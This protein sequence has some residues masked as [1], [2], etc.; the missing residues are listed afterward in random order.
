MVLEDLKPRDIMTPGAFRNAVAA[1]LAVSGSINC[2]KHLQ[3]TAIESRRR[4]RR[5]PLFNELGRRGARVARRAAERADTIEAFEAAGGARALLKQLEPLLDASALTVTGRTVAEN[6]A[7]VAVANPEVIRPIEPAVLRQGADRHPARIA[8]ARKRDRQARR[9]RPR[10]QGAS[11]RAPR[12]STT[13]A[14]T[15]C[16]RSPTAT[17]KRGHV[18]VVRGMGPKGGPGMAGP[19]SSVV[20]ALDSAGLQSDVAFVTDGQ[21]SGLCNKGLTVAEVSPES[22]VGGP[23]SLVEN[24]DRVIEST[25]I[26]ASLEIDVPEPRS[27]PRAACA[28]ANRCC[29]NRAATRQS[30]SAPCSRCPPAPCWSNRDGNDREESMSEM[31]SSP[32]APYAAGRRRDIKTIN[33]DICVLG[34]GISGVAAALE[35]AK[36]G[37]KVVIVDG[38]PAI[39]GQAIGSI[40]GTIIGLYTHGPE[41][42]QITHGIADDLIKDLTA[43][44]SFS[45]CIIRRSYFQY[46][47]VRLGRWMERKIEAAGVHAVVG[48]TLTAVKFKNRRVEHLDFVTRFGPLRV[49]ANG[50]RRLFRRR[51]ALL[52]GRTRGART[53]RARVRDVEFPHRGLQHGDTVGELVMKDVHAQLIAKGKDYGLVRHDGHLMHFPGKN[54]MLANIGHFETPLDPLADREHGVRGPPSGGQH[55]RFLRAE[56]P[57]IFANAR[58]RTYGNPGIRQTRW[59][60]GST[61]ADGRRHPQD[62]SSARCRRALRVVGRTS[63]HEGARA[64]GALPGRSLSITFP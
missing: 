32:L 35:A 7:D 39:G 34:A 23:L 25:S 56:F 14:R 59:I 46:D 27:S 49:V 44:G 1:V 6:L 41:A 55:L 63:Q 26:G 51:Y 8:R 48:A 37:R 12:S 9:A 42:Y 28:G 54:F 43:E 13:A 36:L 17:S 62:G 15:R 60:V 4:R 45:G 38:A 22:A 33:A 40:I 30:I 29:R 18:L 24:G 64:L 52:R 16:R 47:E 21:L 53:R 20:F 5:L 57:R 2:I 10:S 11:S 50:L 58:V 3:A 19:A 61:P 31:K